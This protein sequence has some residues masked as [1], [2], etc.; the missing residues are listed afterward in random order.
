MSPR[1]SK[2]GLKLRLFNLEDFKRKAIEPVAVCCR[3]RYD[4]LG[5]ART[6]LVLTARYKYDASVILVY[7]ELLIHPLKKEPLDAQKENAKKRIQEVVTY[8]KK[9]FEIVDG[10]WETS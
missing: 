8:L 10:E 5:F 6:Y 3:D 2:P 1:K 9:Y 4:A 7:E